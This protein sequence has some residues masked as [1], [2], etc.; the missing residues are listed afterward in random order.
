MHTLVDKRGKRHFF[1]HI[2]DSD[3]SKRHVYLGSEPKKAVDRLAFLR[4]ENSGSRIVDSSLYREMDAV[5]LQLLKLGEFGHPYDDIL[6][7]IRKRYYKRFY[8]E[9]V[10]EKH[11]LD[12]VPVPSRLSLGSVLI[13]LFSLVGIIGLLAFFPDAGITGHAVAKVSDHWFSPVVGSWKL[14]FQSLG[15]FV[16]SLASSFVVMALV[17]ASLLAYG[18]QKAEKRILYR[19]E[20]YKHPL[21][22]KGD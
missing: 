15:S 12:D 8:A 6:K 3:G 21:M 9:K 2:F 5:K 19:D 1:S 7:D 13:I 11:G 18:A 22:R 10:L 14:V 20:E 16:S 4:S 17:L